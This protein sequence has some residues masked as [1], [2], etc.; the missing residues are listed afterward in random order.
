MGSFILGCLAWLILIT[1]FLGAVSMFSAPLIVWTAVAAGILLLAGLIGIMPVVLGVVLWL[2][3]A[4]VAVVLNVPG[5][6]QKLLSGP[7]LA[8]VRKVLPPISDTEREAIEAGTVWWEADLFRGNPDWS[9][10]QGF[11]KPELTQE[12]Q[13]YLD[14]PVEELCEMLD[15]WEITHELNDMP[16]S[17]WRFLGEKRFFGLNIPKQ[18]DGLGFSALAMSEIVMKIGSRSGTAGAT[19]MVPNSLGPGELLAHYGTEDQKNYYLPRLARGEEIPCFGLTGPWAGSDAGAM[20]DGGVVVREKIAGKDVI[21]FRV[22][23]EKRYITLGPIA[24]VLGLAFKAYDPDGI[25]GDEKELGI[26]CALIP[27]DTEG[28]WIGNRHMPLNIA[29]QNGPNRGEEVFVPMDW[30]IGGQEQVGRGWRMLM[31]SLAAGRGIM[32]PASGVTAAKLAARTTGAYSRVREQFNVP[33][34]KFEGVEEALARIGGLTYLME[35]ARLLT[36]AGL[37][38]GEKPSVVS[39]IVKQQ[40]T[41]RAREV[42]NDAMDIHGGRGICL[43]PNNY[44]GRIYQQIPVGITVEGA[45]ILTRSL[46]T[47]GQGAMRCH[48]YLLQEV[49]AAQDSSDKATENFD[50]ILMSHLGYAFSNAAR[51]FFHGITLGFFA[52]TP[53]DDTTRGYYRRLSVQ[54]ASF[55]FLA[56]VTLLILGGALKRR[57]KLSGRFADAMSYMF[58][59][60]GALKHFEDCGSP[61]ED[62]PLLDWAMQ[63][64]TWEIEQALDGILRNFPVPFVGGALRLIV[65]PLGRRQRRPDDR[66]GHRVAELLIAP[67]AA[68]D[69]LTAGIYVSDDPDDITGCLEFAL[70]KAIATEDLRKR[71]RKAG[72]SQRADESFDEWLGARVAASDITDEEASE[73]SETHRLV[74]RVID[75]DDFDPEEVRGIGAKPLSKAVA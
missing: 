65:F 40:L 58:L 5:I 20:M 54:S 74:R 37:L 70:D 56:D 7:L 4:V 69:R 48:P 15:D 34:G 19:V 52:K 47:F 8:R 35:G 10:L 18:Y 39:A 14:G 61:A 23:W 68:R 12:E 24:T 33:I 49:S 43:G 42:T 2:L 44:M 36:C 30:V 45:N 63:Q 57:E 53:G 11:A 21:G 60:S 26:T 66:L 62:K 64:S 67:G 32:L 27:T 73:L 25:L 50:G 28:V 17:V 71:L 22:T 13:E 46:I 51:S 3:F 72:L 41:D 1:A 55:S 31:E 9:K 16:E 29:F 38:A 75:V 59:A 6:R